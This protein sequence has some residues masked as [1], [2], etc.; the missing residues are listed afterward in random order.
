MKSMKCTVLIENTTCQDDL[1]CE[2][3]LSLY[4]E[5][6]KHRIL[7]DTGQSALFIDNAKTLGIDLAQIDTVIISHGHYDHG[8]GLL[9]FLKLNSHATVYLHET[10]FHR[11]YHGPEKYIGLDER[12]QDSPRIKRITED[13][14]LDGEISI[15]CTAGKS[16]IVPVQSF[17]LSELKDGIHHPDQFDH[18]IVLMMKEK[19]QS[20]LISGCSHKGILNYVHWYRPDVL[21]GGFHLKKLHPD[22]H[23]YELISLAEFLKQ[24]STVYYT[25]HCTGE[26]QT[27]LMKTVMKDQLHAIQSGSVIEI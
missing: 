27:E 21:I 16:E 8:G 3:G 22:D 10:A 14:I 23:Q 25:G 4:I 6:K 1:H 20:I 2:H 12:L 7:F 19:N 11:Y 15:L 9:S 13:F 26:K 18:E 24:F 5:S 17:G